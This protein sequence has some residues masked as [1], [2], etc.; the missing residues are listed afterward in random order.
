MGTISGGC[1]CSKHRAMT[2]ASMHLSQL[3]MTVDDLKLQQGMHQVADI[4][5]QWGKWTACMLMLMIP[6]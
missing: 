3:S 4:I 6:L 2:I 1:L 5:M